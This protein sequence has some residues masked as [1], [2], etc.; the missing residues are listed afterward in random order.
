MTNTEMRI[1]IKALY[2][3]GLTMRCI[4][5]QANMTPQNLNRWLNRNV[6]VRYTTLIRIFNAS[7][8]IKAKIA[9]V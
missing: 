8:A 9:K 4:A 6:D 5:K 7:E 1:K 3:A 2:D